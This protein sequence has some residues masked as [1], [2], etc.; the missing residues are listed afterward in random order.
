MI[1][2]LPLSARRCATVHQLGAHE[3]GFVDAHHLGAPVDA[4]DDLRRAR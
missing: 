3:I 2:C 1:T 4:I